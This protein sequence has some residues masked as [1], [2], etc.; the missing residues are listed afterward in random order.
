MTILGI[1]PGTATTGYGVIKTGKDKS[2][3][4]LVDFGVVST[5][6]KLSDAERLKIVAD[7]VIRLIKKFK[8][9][10]V[11]VEKLF[12]TTNQKTAMTVSQARGVVLYVCE[13][14]NLPIYEFTPLQVK[15]FICGYGKADKK[16]VQFMVQKEFKLK[17]PPKP[18]DAADALAVALCAAHYFQKK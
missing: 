13:K 6:S 18:D 8:P 3:Y 14:Q 15:S 2:Q 9:S 17:S 16:Q 10:A 11:G 12:F 7:D 4:N 1:D 5:K